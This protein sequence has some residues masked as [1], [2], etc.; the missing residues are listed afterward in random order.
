MLPIR[1]VWLSCMHLMHYLLRVPGEVMMI[2][3]SVILGTHEHASEAGGPSQVSRHVKSHVAR[4]DA[5]ALSCQERVWHRGACGDVG[6]LTCWGGG[7]EP[8]DKRRHQS[9]PSLGDGPGATG[10]VVTLEPSWEAGSSTTGHVVTLEPSRA[11]RW[12]WLRGTRGDARAVP[13]WEVGSGATGHVVTLEP[14]RVGRQGL[15]LW[16]S[17]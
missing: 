14:S 17:T 10:H 2:L 7:L 3:M 12:V 8:W 16:D 9:P 13:C 15:V 5:G 11:G 4:G 6:A 1:R